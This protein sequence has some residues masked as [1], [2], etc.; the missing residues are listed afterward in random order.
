MTTVYDIDELFRL[1]KAARPNYT[2]FCN[3]GV[4]VD[5]LWIAQQPKIAFILK[6]AN[7]GFHEIRGR[8]HGPNGTSKV[9][10]RNLSM[11]SFT[12]KQLLSGASVTIEEAMA[13]KE[14]PVG[15]IAYINI[16]KKGEWRSLSD[17]KDIQSFADDDWVF[18]ERQI[19]LI[20]P[21]VI[22]CCGTYRYIAHHLL[23][24]DDGHGIYHWQ[25]KIV[26][27][28]CHPSCRKGYKETFRL[29][30]QMIQSSRA[31]FEAT[32]TSDV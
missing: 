7:D 1:W 6:E 19:G 14:E 5:A 8:C 4:L 30:S 29:L 22:F 15:H 16:K 27:D 2:H 11:W 24:K 23:A 31:A 20:G 17:H 25:G 32:V 26:I 9:F 12:A 21:D 3:D 13:H 28:F 10:W 18:L